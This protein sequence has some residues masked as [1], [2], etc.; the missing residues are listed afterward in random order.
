MS[1]IMLQQD[2][3]PVVEEEILLDETEEEALTVEDALEDLRAAIADMEEKEAVLTEKLCIAK[4]KGLTIQAE[5]CRKL[6]QRVIA[7]KR[8]MKEELQEAEA[9]QLA[10]EIDEFA[11]ALE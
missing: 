4:Q 11:A 5:K 7:E 2:N 9:F 8:A 10:S 6:L 1:D 3:E